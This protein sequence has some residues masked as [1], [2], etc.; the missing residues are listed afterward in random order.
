MACN[1]GGE[2]ST[3]TQTADTHKTENKPAECI[4]GYNNSATTVSWTSYKFTKKAAVGGK[5]DRVNV[6]TQTQKGQPAEILKGIEFTIPVNSTNTNNPD[7]D[8]K[9]I[10]YFFKAMVNTDNIIGRI[11]SVESNG[12]GGHAT[13]NL[14]MNNVSKDIDANFKISDTSIE[15]IAEINMEDFNGQDAI[16]SLNK[17]CFD[18]HK[19]EDGVSKLWPNVSIVVTSVLTKDCN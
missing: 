12:N 6:V 3:E 15:L 8:K 9:I 18:L 13:I 5:F 11:T 2:S 16:A 17:Q 14:Q 4:Y 1:S 7:R 10:D 19:G